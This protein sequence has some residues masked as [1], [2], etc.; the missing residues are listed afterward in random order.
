MLSTAFLGSTAIATVLAVSAAAAAPLTVLDLLSI[1][2]LANMVAQS[3]VVGLR[4][5]AD[6]RYVDLDLRPLEGRMAL[7]GLEVRP[8]DQED[9]P[10]CSV[11]V[12]RAVLTS[13]PLDQIDRAALDL[14]LMSLHVANGC[15]DASERRGLADIGLSDIDIDRASVRLDYTFA[16]GA[17]DLEFEIV[18]PGLAA[19]DGAIAFDYFAVNVDEE[20]PVMDLR[21]AR[22]QLIDDGGWTRISADLPPQ[23]FEPAALA[24]LLTDEL[25][26]GSAEA[27]PAPEAPGGDGDGDKGGNG[28]VAP[29]PAPAPATA[30]PEAEA[31]ARAFITA[32]AEAIATFAADPGRLSLEVTPEL[33]V[34]LTEDLVEDF[35]ALVL[36]LNPVLTAGDP[37]PPARLEASDGAAILALGA[38]E[39]VDVSDD[40]R[41][42]LARALL[43]GSGVPRNPELGQ[44]LLDPLLEAENGE[45][46]ALVLEHAELF[47]P[48]TAYAAA[49]GA[50]A[51]FDRAALARLDRLERRLG[52]EAALAVQ[53]D[54]RQRP[55]PDSDQDPRALREMAVAALSGFGAPRSYADAYFLALLAQAGGDRGAAA[56]LREVE[57]MGRLLEAPAD[58]EALLADL[59][60]EAVALWFGADAE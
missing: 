55:Q 26:P 50:A 57:S 31:A 58:W 15:F 25:L 33:P 37:V 22:M 43:T 29:P 18:A 59:R 44:A 5:V 13:A 45:A 17:L 24:A 51:A 52:F 54:G 30:D 3:A 19:V 8:Y 34:R 38:G 32:S 21:H 16:T 7:T 40:R 9:Y 11:T 36:A 12:D 35:A 46:L 1:D 48:E 20:E 39:T 6:L 60:A 47:A 42:A 2:R 53:L 27:P 23:M 10:G 41:L 14:E 56:I 49:R 4:G 28:D